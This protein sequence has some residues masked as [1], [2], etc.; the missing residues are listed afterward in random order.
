MLLK[1]ITWYWKAGYEHRREAR[2]KR[3][4][5]RLKWKYCH[6]TLDNPL[7]NQIIRDSHFIVCAGMPGSGKTILMLLLAK[8]LVDKRYYLIDKQKREYKYTQ[9]DI[10]RQEDNLHAQKLLPVYADIHIN[11]ENN[12]KNDDLGPYL[13][14][15]RKALPYS[16]FLIDEIGESFGKDIIYDTETK[17]TQNVLSKVFRYIRQDI[18][19]HVIAT[20]QDG[21]N[22]FLGMRRIGYTTITC[23]KTIKKLS[24]VGKIKRCLY[25]FV[26]KW[27]PGVFTVNM[28]RV[29][30][31][32]LYLGDRL[33]TILKLLLPSFWSA[34][35][36]YYTR[37]N[38]IYAKIK[39]KYMRFNL[40][41]QYN[42]AEY[43]ITFSL[44]DVY[45]YDTHAHKQSYDSM[46]DSDG[47][48]KTGE[49]YDNQRCKTDN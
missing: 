47:K 30:A 34:P 32:Y 8:F 4:N 21:Q 22:I 18:E 37:K 24:T 48:R 10:L 40:L 23:K 35:Q 6:V 42:N 49:Y 15:F 9:P 13:F 1:I 44:Q 17:S 29:L 5:E 46:F 2:E 16:V 31:Q 27:M 14:Q 20:E 45:E 43:Y 12:Y 36:E 33:I 3:R 41:F 26:N 11:D 39:H 28:H 19:G 38:E 7:I 25:N